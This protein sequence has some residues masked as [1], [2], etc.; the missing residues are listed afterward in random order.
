MSDTELSEFNTELQKKYK[1]LKY[2]SQQ[3]QIGQPE[4]NFCFKILVND[5]S[6][7]KYKEQRKTKLLKNKN[8]MEGD[9]QLV[10]IE[11]D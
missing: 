2:E 8:L 4:D 1:I 10:K 6:I 5:K 11:D 7:Q 3:Y 9:Q